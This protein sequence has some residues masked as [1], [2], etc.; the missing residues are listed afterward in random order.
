LA[1]SQA[2]HCGRS[3]RQVVLAAMNVTANSTAHDLECGELPGWGL[4]IGVVMGIIGSVGINVGQNLQAAGL[5]ALALPMRTKPCN[6]RVWVIGM[7]IFISF[8]MLNFAALALAPASILT[9]LESIQFVS[10]VIY[11]KV[12]NDAI[13]SRRACPHAISS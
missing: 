6:S 8:S 13:V 5:Q 7:V 12:V 1:A 11:N 2:V 4:Y 10:N 3:L 9:P